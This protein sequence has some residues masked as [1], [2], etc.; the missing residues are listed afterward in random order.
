[1]EDEV[2]TEEYKKINLK[3]SVF[4][5]F[6]YD[7]EKGD[8]F[9]NH[10]VRECGMLDNVITRNSRIEIAI[11]G[12]ESYFIMMIRLDQIFFSPNITCTVFRECHR[13]FIFN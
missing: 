11:H 4:W 12:M 2:I 7:K 3:D 8:D 9:L 5:S 6:W 13:E 10:T 1:M